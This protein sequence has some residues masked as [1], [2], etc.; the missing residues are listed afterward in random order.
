[1]KKLALILA[2]LGVLLVGAGMSNTAAA[3]PPGPTPSTTTTVSPTTSVGPDQP[4]DITTDVPMVDPGGGFTATVT[5][6]LPGETVVFT[7]DGME[8]TA[9]CDGTTQQAS[10]PFVAPMTPGTYEVC[11]ELTGTGATVPSGVTRPTTVC[12]TI[13]VIGAGAPGTPTIP[14]GG[15]PATGSSG[16]GTTT[17]SAI[18][19]LGAG[20]LLLVVAQVRRRRTAPTTA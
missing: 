11:A 13:E 9:T 19:L 8:G 18:V 17:T 3:Y 12:T 20:A 4:P 7:V 2:A 16:L 14:G 15:L 6:C 10:F 1:M 5:N